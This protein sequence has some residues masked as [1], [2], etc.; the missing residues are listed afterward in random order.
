M[1]YLYVHV[2]LLLYE[3]FILQVPLPK[4]QVDRKI[5]GFFLRVFE[6]LHVQSSKGDMDVGAFERV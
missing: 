3:K 4:L 2:F 5:D 1:V 6:S